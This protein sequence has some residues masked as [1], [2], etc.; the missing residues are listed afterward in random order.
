MPIYEYQCKKCGFVFEMFVLSHQE[1]T[2]CPKCSSEN[3]E[4]LISAPNLGRNSNV[5]GYSSCG[6]NK[7]GFS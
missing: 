7:S 1:K 3:V 6:G 4:K 5:S 2:R